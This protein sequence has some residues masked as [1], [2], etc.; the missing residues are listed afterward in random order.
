MIQH[1]NL[2]F[3]KTQEIYIRPKATIGDAEKQYTKALAL[4]TSTYG[5]NSPEYADILL[6]QATLA[7]DKGDYNISEPLFIQALAI[8][9]ANSIAAA[10]I[11]NNLGTLFL[12]MGRLDEAQPQFEKALTIYKNTNGANLTDYVL[13]EENLAAL[14]N[15]RGDTQKALSLLSETVSIN[16][17]IYG[18]E[19]PN[20]A[21]SLHNYASL[22]QKDKK[23]GQAKP[24]FKEALAIQRA[25][26]GVNHLS[27]T[28]T[29][30]NLAILAED[31]KD[32]PRADSLLNKVIEIRATL[33]DE[34]H[35]SYTAAL[36]SRAVL[37][38][39]MN[40]FELA[41][42][43]FD[44]VADLYLNQIIKYFPN[45]SE[46]EKT[47][48]YKKITPVFNRYKEFLL[49]YY[50]NFNKDE[51]VLGQLYNIQIATKAILLNSINKTR[52]RILASGNPQLINDFNE[53][54]ALKKQLATYYT[55]SKIK[56]LEEGVEIKTYESIVNTKEKQLS[57]ASAL[58]AH[59]F[60]K[61]QTD[62]Q[63]I[64]SSLKLDQVALEFI[65]IKRNSNNQPDSVTYIALAISSAFSHPKLVIY[66]NGKKLENKY[67]PSYNNS[68]IY[69]RQ[70]NFSYA[71]YWEPLSSVVKDFK[72]VYISAD[73]VFNKINA[74]SFFNNQDSTYLTISHNVR[75]I[76]STRDLLN[77]KP[78]AQTK[79][80]LLLA[81][82]FYPNSIKLA[83]NNIERSYKFNTITQLPGTKKEAE[84]IEDLMKK[85]GWTVNVLSDKMAQKQDIINESPSLLHIAAHGFFLQKDKENTAF[86][87]NP[88]FRSGL[89]LAGA[90]DADVKVDN[91]GILTAYEVMNMNL[92]Q[93]ELVVL[94]ACETALG[95]VQNGEGV[96]GL[97]RAF[98][99][100]GANTLIMSLWK[101]D[102]TATQKLMSA[103]YTYWLS[104]IDKHEAL[105]KAQLDIQKEYEYPYYW[106][107]FIMIG[108]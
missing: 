30:H 15:L 80:A 7:K 64:Q 13:T 18:N 47:A 6:R 68:I 43:D 107:A 45:L 59:E 70:D 35:P 29:L 5:T 65:R 54:R 75:Y 37:R 60:D 91:A 12:Q 69:K 77:Y 90:G 92:D 19:S 52:N 82:P 21:I 93:T 105:Q 61:T 8:V 3:Y 32:Y 50:E 73:G 97:Q 79:K 22:L 41:K 87:D 42:Q 83:S 1:F 44:K 95:D 104:G 2:N 72:T 67:L 28:N 57:A 16:K 89:L 51:A 33:F 9:E 39:Q 106:A 17:K 88:L 96:Y 58:F 94:S 84:D 26:F 62:W 100:A 71:A 53:W 49:E 34:N 63:A 11:N 86:L 99:I 66:P 76:S 74:N 55:F 48:F 103:F 40:Q 24:L 31:E 102:D 78:S 46:K 98:I 36:Y 56:L 25:N 20:Y 101:V 27:Y 4:A 81:D 14:Y 23:P 108:I 10:G 38:Q 85:N